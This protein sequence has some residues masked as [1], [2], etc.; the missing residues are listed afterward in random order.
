[1]RDMQHLRATVCVIILIPERL[2]PNAEAAAK[3]KRFD[4]FVVAAS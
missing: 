1:M 2:R 3:Q 4:L